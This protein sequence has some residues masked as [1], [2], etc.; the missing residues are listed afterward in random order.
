MQVKE[1]KLPN[2]AAQAMTSVRFT[3]FEDGD[4]IFQQIREASLNKMSKP[5]MLGWA[6]G[7][8]WNSS[9]VRVI[10]LILHS[11]LPDLCM[12]KGN[13]AW[14]IQLRRFSEWKQP[15]P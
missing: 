1:A 11:K 7:L 4:P 15:R 5:S 12:R 9:K 3:Q 14:R 6:I 13:D 8:L 2:H 10:D